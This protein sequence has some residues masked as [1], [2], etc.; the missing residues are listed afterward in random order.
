[1]AKAGVACD[2]TVTERPGHAA[3]LAKARSS[4]QDAVFALGGD[5]TVMEIAGALAGTGCPIGILAGGTGNLLC[6]ALGIPLTVNRAVPALLHGD[7]LPIDLGRFS[8]GRR[9]AIAAGVGIDAAMV[10]ETSEWLKRQLGVFA[11]VLIGTR[12]AVRAV[13]RQ[14]F[15][16]GRIT[17]DGVTNECRAAAIMVANFGAVLG[18]RIT[19]GPDVRA[20]D[21]LL[22]VCMFAP[23]SL[24]DAV[25]IMWRL[26][27]RDFSPHPY[28]I[29]R[30]GRH[31]EIDTDPPR[32]V[33][34]DGEMVGMTPMAMAVEP[35]A[36]HLLIPHRG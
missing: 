24:T 20:D 27:R 33:Q 26:L 15:V 9:F 28:M 5:G 1:M 6:R 34:A 31:I 18:D 14:D 29:Y 7:V 36:A 17:V 12:A 3:E 30:R 35:L 4:D 19:L 16:C 10:A 22:D 21:G 13:V 23:R 11:Y 2:L 32:A 8:T 25:R